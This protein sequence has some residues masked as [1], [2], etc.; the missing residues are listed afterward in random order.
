MHSH[1]DRYI[2]TCKTCQQSLIKLTEH[3]KKLDKT[4]T[5]TIPEK[6]IPDVRYKIW[7]SNEEIKKRNNMSKVKLSDQC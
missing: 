6:L 4:G 5:W 7:E 2:K 1:S 3:M